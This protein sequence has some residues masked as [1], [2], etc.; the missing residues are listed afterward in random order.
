M[1]HYG[2]EDWADFARQVASPPKKR[3]AMQRHLEQGCAKC[4]KAFRLW[5]RVLDLARGEAFYHP[6]ASAVRVVQ[7]LYALHGPPA[8]K[9]RATRLARLLLDSFR[10]PLPAGARATGTSPR[11]LLYQVGK[12]FVDLRMEPQAGSN[13]LSVVGQVFDSAQ[14]HTGMQDIPVFLANAEGHCARATTNRFGEF[15][16][17]L[18]SYGGSQLVLSVGAGAAGESLIP[19]PLG[20]ARSRR[21]RR[22]R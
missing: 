2:E 16:L 7:G 13:R 22:P 4:S 1:K 6:P 20:A 11:Q 14:P 15:H 3:A 5:Q 19:I 17:E 12:L 8:T 21:P 10:K 18:A 9:S